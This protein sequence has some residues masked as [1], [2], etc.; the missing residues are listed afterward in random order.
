MRFCVRASSVRIAGRAAPAWLFALLALALL[1]GCQKQD[2]ISRYTVKKMPVVERPAK[3][4]NPPGPPRRPAGHGPGMNERML[5]AIASQGRTFW[6]FKVAGPKDTVADQMP[7]FLSLIQSLKF[8]KDEALPP[9][10]TLPEGWTEKKDD[11]PRGMRFT[12]L[13]VKTDGEDL[14]LTVTRLPLPGDRPVDG[15][16]LMIVNLWCEQLGIPEK[17]AA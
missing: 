2:E 14:P 11:D 8:G 5:G 17:T 12:T 10:W 15:M 7:H 6:V 16:P 3:A 9:E 4:Q 1:S 13:L